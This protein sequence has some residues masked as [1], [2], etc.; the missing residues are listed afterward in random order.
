MSWHLA[1]GLQQHTE[2]PVLGPEAGSWNCFLPAGHKLAFSTCCPVL[3][4]PGRKDVCGNPYMTSEKW[5][6]AGEQGPRQLPSGVL[7][8]EERGR[9][10]CSSSLARHL[11]QAPALQIVQGQ[12]RGLHLFT[13]SFIR[14]FTY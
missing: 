6:D 14:S 8:F 10:I 4:D 11:S 2:L 9:G 1:L 12:H 7:L 3:P 5:G 13:D